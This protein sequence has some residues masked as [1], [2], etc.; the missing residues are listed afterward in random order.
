MIIT[1]IIKHNPYKHLPKGGCCLF[2]GCGKHIAYNRALS[3]SIELCPNHFQ[4]I[5]KR[6]EQLSKIKKNQNG[7]IH[8][9]EKFNSDNK[10]RFTYVID[11]KIFKVENEFDFCYQW[12]LYRGFDVRSCLYVA[13]TFDLPECNLFDLVVTSLQRDIIKHIRQKKLRMVLEN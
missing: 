5:E 11:D 6:K 13:G 7:L 4:Q 8:Y 2:A 10:G 9:L 12:L 1:P 3:L